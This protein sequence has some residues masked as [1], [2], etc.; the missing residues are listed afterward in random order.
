MPCLTTVPSRH[1]FGAV[2]AGLQELVDRG[3]LAGASHAVLSGQELVDVGYAG[4]ADLEARIALREDHLFRAFS[5]SKLITSI[6]VLQLWEQGHFALDDPV[7]RFIPQ[8]GQRRV[9]Q[10]GA[11]RIDDTEPARGPITVR[12]LLTH[13]AGL[14]YGL[15]DPGTVIFDAYNK[16]R[17]MHPQHTLAQMM[18]ALEPLPLAFHPGSSWEYSVATDVLARL[19][20]IVTGRRFGEA[21]QRQVLDPL[22][23]ADTGFVVP[24]SQQHRLTGYYLGADP[25]DPMKP[26]LTRVDAT[27]PFPGAYLRPLPRQSGGGGLVSSLPDMVRLMRCLLPGGPALL[28]PETLASMMSDQLPPGLT[29][30][31]PESG[32]LFGRSHALAGGLIRTPGPLDAPGAAGEFYWGGVAGTL[33]WIHPRSATSGLLM[34]QRV[35]GYSHPVGPAFKRSV[36]EALGIVADRTPPA[37]RG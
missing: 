22:G 32:P 9:I 1:D 8:L 17:V 11:R 3:V 37:P 15:F 5:N 31:F 29:L 27:Q 18:D 26:G 28:K 30:R 20:E 35:M 21:L 23:M 33:W 36:Y 25:A 16:A 2:H 12:H 6:A 34:I 13:T 10:P 19:V 4:W 7:E 14:S 24:E